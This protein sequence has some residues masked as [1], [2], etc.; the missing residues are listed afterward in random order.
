VT[1]APAQRITKRYT[2]KECMK[3]TLFSFPVQMCLTRSK[4]NED[5]KVSDENSHAQDPA[6]REYHEACRQAYDEVNNAFQE[7]EGKEE[8]PSNLF[9]SDA[10]DYPQLL[11]NKKVHVDYGWDLDRINCMEDRSALETPIRFAD[12]EGDKAAAQGVH[13]FESHENRQDRFDPGGTLLIKRSWRNANEFE[14]QLSDM[15]VIQEVPDKSSET[16]ASSTCNKE[17]V[18]PKPSAWTSLVDRMRD[19]IRQREFVIEEHRQFLLI[20]INESALRTLARK[21]YFK[22]DLKENYLKKLETEFEEFTNAAVEWV[23]HGLSLSSL[24][25]IYRAKFTMATIERHGGSLG[26]LENTRKFIRWCTTTDGNVNRKLMKALIAKIGASDT[27]SEAAF[28]RIP[29]AKN[30]DS[31]HE[32]KGEFAPVCKKIHQM[33]DASSLPAPLKIRLK[34][35]TS[36]NCVERLSNGQALSG[37]ASREERALL[38]D[39]FVEDIGRAAIKWASKGLQFPCLSSLFRSTITEKNIQ[40]NGGAL[41]M[42]ETAERIIELCTIDGMLHEPMTHMITN[43]DGVDLLSQDRFE[44]IKAKYLAGLAGK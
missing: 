9:G 21:E 18:E 22:G 34:I 43:A 20:G 37:P 14:D 39:K 12:D 4:P 16:V 38:A 25:S 8:N 5:N 40:R 2:E 24:R 36:E 33:I 44:K 11:P 26:V 3:P 7:S 28:K 17:T 41:K 10:Y 15:D 30:R 27:I 23:S 29:T 19:I 42:L 32:P 35:D 6:V 13:P 1:E 31:L